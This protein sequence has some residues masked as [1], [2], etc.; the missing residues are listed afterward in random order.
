MKP[1]ERLWAKMPS[2]YVGTSFVRIIV[3]KDHVNIEAK[4]AVEY[5]DELAGYKMTPKG[6]LQIFVG[7][8]IPFDVLKRIFTEILG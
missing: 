6:M 1:E 5:K 4:T 3:F 7:P 2:Y 8:E